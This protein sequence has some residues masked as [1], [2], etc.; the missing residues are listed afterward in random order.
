MTSIKNAATAITRRAIG[1]V[2]RV[3]LIVAF[4][5]YGACGA[6]VSAAPLNIENTPLF[7]IGGV[8]P[9]LIMAIDDSGSMDFEV[10]LAGNDGSAWWR[11]DNTTNGTCTNTVNDGSFTGCIS[12]GTADIASAGKLNFN[13]DGVSGT[14]WKKFSYLF[15]NGSAG[16]SNT[17]DRKRLVD[18]TNDHF[19]I[20]PIGAFAWARSPEHNVSY[21]DPAESYDYWVSVTGYPA[22]PFTDADPDTAQYDPVFDGAGSVDLTRDIAGNQNVATVET[23]PACASNIATVA[24]DYYFRVYTGMTIPQGACIRR[25]GTWF[26]GAGWVSVQGGNCVVG[27]TLGCPTSINGAA[28]VNRTLGDAQLVAIRYFPATFYASAAGAPAAGYGYTATPVADGLA[29]DGST[30]NRYEIKLANF[31]DNDHYEKA[32]QN[33]A[34]WFTYYR[35]RHLALRAGLGKAFDP[36][37]NMRIAGFTINSATTTG[38]DVTMGSIDV[39]ANK[40]AL[41]TNFYSNWVRSG[42]T[43]NRTAV[44]NVV[45]NFK[46][47]NAGAPV[48]NS[49]QRNFGM[50]FT[51]GFSN[52]PAAGDGIVTTNNDGDD[53]S[54]FDEGQ[55]YTDT[56][57]ATVADHVMSAYETTIRADLEQ[58]K[59]AVPIACDD[60]GHDPWLDCNRNPHMNFYAIT[61]GTRGRIFDP[62]VANVESAGFTYAATTPAGWAGAWPITWPSTFPAR[63]PHA[64]DD[65]WHAA[66]NGRGQLL[67]ARKSTDLADKLSAVL[68]S[69][70]SQE[71]SAA[72]ASVSSGTVSAQI[73]NRTFTV[74]FDPKTW[75]GRL[76]AWELQPDGE[77]GEPVTATIDPDP[78][79]RLIFTSAQGDRTD[80]VPFLWGDIGA[81]RQ[82][83]LTPF[84]ASGQDRLN[85]VRGDRS[86]EGGGGLR[87]RTAVPGSAPLGDI[88]G[89]APVYVGTP[90]FRYR[91]TFEADAYSDF[92]AANDT[93]AERSRM[94]YVGSN[95]GMLH[96]FKT[97]DEV[98]GAM[99]EAF[100]YIPSPVIRNLRN[101]ASPAYSHRYF[102]DGTPSVQDAFFAKGGS[103]SPEWRTVLAGGLNRGGQGVYVLDITAPDDIDSNSDADELL[104]WEFTDADDEDLGYTYSRPAVVRT[105]N[106]DWVVVFGN[107]YNNTEA[108]GNQS[109]TGNAVL[110]FVDLATGDL[111]RKITLPA[112]TAQD[113][114]GAARPNGLATPAVVDID[115]DDIVD[116]A[117]AGDLFGNMWKFNLTSNDENTWDVAI[118]D[119]TTAAALPMFVARNAAGDYQPITT[120]PQV[121]RGPRGFGQVVLFGTGKFM[122]ADDRVLATLDVQSFYGIFD[123]AS[124]S[125]SDIVARADLQQQTIDEQNTAGELWWRVT[126]NTAVNLTTKRGWYMNLEYGTF[127]GEMQITDSV[128]RSGR[129][130]F[131]TLIPDT[132]PCSYGGRSW[133]MLVDAIN[134]TRLASSPIDVNNDRLF[135]EDDK[136]TLADSSQEYISGFGS[137][138]IM[139]QVRFVASP[140]GDLGLVTDTANNVR[141]VLLNPGPGRLGRQSWRQLR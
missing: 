26:A 87:S 13:H 131:T 9:N 70:S 32:I 43:P 107:G 127:D 93:N 135:S 25:S 10:L 57:S 58:G 99:T 48:T 94:V 21:F 106:G 133:F 42:G 63:H 79:A 116:Y 15:P 92:V 69:V 30:L 45:R 12:S 113:P 19:A 123:R 36:V 68:R 17:S 16:G 66:I 6:L 5:G 38:P 76:R 8:S 55:P 104:H 31:V 52:A 91:A 108:D 74:S 27:T 88:V 118:K 54:D 102:V 50:L 83:L 67:N 77:L 80:G 11:A 40:T 126:S 119:G 34:N 110:Y 138:S 85:Y 60:V 35:K 95:D 97:T 111:I 29:P 125:T 20:P 100:S 124:N 33:F 136:V 71:G 49:C 4:A 2:R 132:D 130:A 47:T 129:I 82:A 62:D 114:T 41:Y 14:N 101:L 137:S 128:L 72:S 61:L 64:V 117:Y 112:G 73:D 44:A 7:L 103:G 105:H 23:T 115:G 28:T 120:R 141:S 65:L 39:V 84:A 122:E 51:D 139:A 53:S 1:Q 81:V 86:L 98:D 24:A 140:D 18:S 56:V 78:T 75:S 90:P 134:G 121:G 96:A 37:T 3:G 46:R 89:S 109:A 22:T 59:V